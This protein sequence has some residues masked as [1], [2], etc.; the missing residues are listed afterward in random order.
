M[1][2]VSELV[3][4]DVE[5]VGYPGQVAAV[6]RYRGPAPDVV[7]AVD[8]LPGPPRAVPRYELKVVGGLVPVGYPG[9]VAAVQRYRVEPP[10]V[11]GVVERQGLV[12]PGCAV[13]VRVSKGVVLVVVV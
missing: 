12:H 8:H 5:A 6:D 1:G 4:R 11:V 13:V 7:Q 9:V 3:E 10:V 2:G